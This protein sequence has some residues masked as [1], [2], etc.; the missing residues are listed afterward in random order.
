MGEAPLAETRC[1]PTLQ[2]HHPDRHQG[3]DAAKKRFQASRSAWRRGA[4]SKTSFWRPKSPSSWAP[5]EA[6]AVVAAVP[7][8][9]LLTT[10]VSRLQDIVCAFE[11][12]SDEAQRH[13]Y[14]LG[15]LELLDV[16]E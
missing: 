10:C 14:D 8:A 5:A 9:T 15:L 3:C 1:S 7:A 12:L 11:V 6:P 16:E 13:L 2:V 4:L